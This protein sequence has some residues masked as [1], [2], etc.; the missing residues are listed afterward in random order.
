MPLGRADLKGGLL[1]LGA[2]LEEASRIAGGS[3]LV[4]FRRIVLRLLG[5][6]LLT[7][8]LIVFVGAARNVSYVAL[9]STTTNQPLSMLQLNYLAEG[10]NEDSVRYRLYRDAQLRRR[11]VHSPSRRLPRR[12]DMT[13]NRRGLSVSKPQLRIRRRRLLAFAGISGVAALL[14]ACALRRPPRPPQP[15]L[16]AQAPS[17]SRP[18]RRLGQGAR[19]RQI[20]GRHDRQHLP[21]LRQ[22]DRHWRNSARRT[23]TSSSSKPHWCPR[24]S[25]PRSCR[26][27]RRASIPGTC[28]ISQLPPR[29]RC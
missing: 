8:G 26:S 3:W 15:R 5:P 18:R 7:V 22:S 29:S 6:S 1:Q 23:R 13:F 25:R 27:A 2:E 14:Q 19:R 10:K 12:S 20:G 9:L 11:G 21:G 16:L 17:T 4:T 24:R 28:C